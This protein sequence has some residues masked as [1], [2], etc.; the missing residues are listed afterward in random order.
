MSKSELI[1]NIAKKDN[2]SRKEAKV[3]VESVLGEIESGLKCLK[4]SGETYTLTGFG[5][6]FIAKRK[7]RDGINP[8]TKEKIK[9]K[10]SKSLKFRPYAQLKRAAGCQ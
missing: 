8:Q 5:T 10:A 3:R 6:F 7:A 9:I 1:D 2:I 4:K